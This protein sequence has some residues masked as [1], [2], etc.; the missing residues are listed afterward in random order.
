MYVL[1]DLVNTET[2]QFTIFREAKHWVQGRYLNLRVRLSGKIF[3]KNVF[4]ILNLG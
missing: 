1:K 3:P 2:N 4:L